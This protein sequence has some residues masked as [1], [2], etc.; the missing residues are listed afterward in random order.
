M[1]SNARPCS[2]TIPL[3]T[4]PT[5][6]GKTALSLEL[7]E[8]LNAEIISADSRQIYREL[9]IGTAK[10]NPDELAV[11]PHHF[12]NERA[13]GEAYSSGQFA[14][15][16]NIRIAEIFGCDRLP[17]VVGGSTLY[18]HALV[19]GLGPTPSAHP[20]IRHDLEKRFAEKGADT[21]YET[22]RTVDPDTAR[23]MDAT[24][25]ARV[26]RALEV[27][28]G[29]GIP[30][31]HYHAIKSPPAF[32]FRVIVLNRDRAD[33]YGRIN[34]RVNEMLERGLMTEVRSLVASGHEQSLS[35]LRTI[36]YREAIDHLNGR[37]AYSEMVRLIQRNT[38][39]Y[40]KRQLTWFRRYTNTTWLRLN[41]RGLD[42]LD[43]D[44]L[45]IQSALA[46]P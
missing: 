38:R 22:L 24:K 31:S 2:H 39:R 20:A 37:T 43:Q 6:V 12:I 41:E 16:A 21:M 17:L 10:P 9:T 4:G 13:L 14:R 29:T 1:S 42:D 26:I 19:H 8:Q 30:L 18:V 34:R 11:V 5:G 46:H 7:A 25:T 35:D 3:L 32:D 36:G 23:T 33:L 27:W 15:E 28:Y 45:R 44:V 40:A